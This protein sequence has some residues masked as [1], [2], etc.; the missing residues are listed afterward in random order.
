MTRTQLAG[1][2]GVSP[3]VIE[4]AEGGDLGDITLEE[5][6]NLALICGYVPLDLSMQPVD[7]VTEFSAQSAERVHSVVEFER[8]R[9]RRD[10]QELLARSP[11]ASPR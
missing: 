1:R 11:E 4:R 8:W 6:V 7:E 2:V 10:I 5:F 3:D 9:L